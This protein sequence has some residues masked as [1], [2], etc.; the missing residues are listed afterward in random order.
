[1]SSSSYNFNVGS[2]VNILY[3]IRNPEILR[4]DTWFA[5]WGFG[6]ILLVS[7]VVP[8]GIASFIGRLS[9]RKTASTRKT[10][11]K[12]TFDEI[13]EEMIKIPGRVKG[14][15]SRESRSDHDREK[16]YIPTVRRNR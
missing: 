8:F 16:N 5:T 7:S 1:M 11:E 10:R 14:L 12:R 6:L 2:K 9:G 13:E 3:D 15:I 4:M